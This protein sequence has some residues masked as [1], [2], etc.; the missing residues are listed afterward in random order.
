MGV[1]QKNILNYYISKK[2]LGMLA[3]IFLNLD[4]VIMAQHRFEDIIKIEGEILFEENSRNVN[5]LPAIS[6]DE[7]GNFILTDFKQNLVRIYDSTGILSDQFGRSGRG[8]GDFEY[9]TSTIRLS[10][11][12]LLTTE[13]S[14]KLS[15]FTNDGN[16]LLKTYNTGVF[17]L[18]KVHRVS[19]DTV[20]LVGRKR[21][22]DVIM[23][24]HLFDV[25]TGKIQKSFLEFPA[26]EK[27][28]GGLFHSIAEI[29]TVSLSNNNKIA[30]SITPFNEIYLYNTEGEFERK[31]TLPFKYFERVKKIDRPLNS[32]ESRNLLST[33]SLI[34]KIFWL[35]ENT[36][37]VQYLIHKEINLLEIEVEYSL[38]TVK[39]DGTILFDINNTPQLVAVEEKSNQIFFRSLDYLD[40]IKLIKSKIK[41]EIKVN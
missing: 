2:V 24:L 34:D 1:Y 7:K 5:V 27:E 25:S 12:K 10:S 20:L 17:P 40:G 19:N 31:V 36:F 15:L 6:I 33:F 8:P 3:L 4:V 28:Y 26:L 22:N 11:G 35:D 39:L 14:G 29:A 37:L 16:S 21:N 30:A 41:K 18:I 13:M 38:A 23:L 9:P 32:Q